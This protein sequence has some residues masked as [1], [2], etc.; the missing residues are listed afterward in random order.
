MMGTNIDL[1]AISRKAQ[2]EL[3]ET[4]VQVEQISRNWLVKA[5]VALRW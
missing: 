2:R 3:W 5:C 1:K 4:I